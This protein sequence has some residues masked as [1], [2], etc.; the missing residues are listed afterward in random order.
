MLWRASVQ[1]P[2][3]MTIKLVEDLI[4]GTELDTALRT[5]MKSRQSVETIMS[6]APLTDLLE[7]IKTCLVIPTKDSKAEEDEPGAEG[8]DFDGGGA[9]EGELPAQVSR[10]LS[11]AVLAA[12]NGGEIEADEKAA[13]MQQ[14]IDKC[15]RKVDTY[16]VL[17]QEPADASA[18]KEML[19][20][21]EV[22][23]LRSVENPT[24]ISERR[25]V[26]INYDLK[27]AGEASS[28]PSTRLPPLRN[29]GDHLKSLMRACISAN[30]EEI[31]SRDL[32]LI[33]DGGRP[34]NHVFAH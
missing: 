7:D 1:P 12:A 30:G 13:K 9:P 33:Y 2:M 15:W 5:G 23:R 3:D 6:S 29:N 25:F 28:H 10:A 24:A 31:G 16:V 17:C 18:L 4:F 19:Q 20:D 8:D 26:L 14:Y 34:G 21:T 11:Q 32:F 27:T 22:N